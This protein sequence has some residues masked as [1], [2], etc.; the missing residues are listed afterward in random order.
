[1]S[2]RPT[3]P[4]TAPSVS[5][6]ALAG[7]QTTAVPPQAPT[8]PPEATSSPSSAQQTP[9]PSGHQEVTT[10]AQRIQHFLRRLHSDVDAA[11]IDAHREA[12]QREL[13]LSRPIL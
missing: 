1:M 4:L 9:A 13:G 3:P 5:D 6:P 7:P 8:V 2:S 11:R 10:M 12:V